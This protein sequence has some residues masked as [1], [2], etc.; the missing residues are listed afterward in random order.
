MLCR[1]HLHLVLHRPILQG[2]Q[3]LAQFLHLV[4]DV[5][6]LGTQALVVRQVELFHILSAC[7]MLSRGTEE[8]HYTGE[9]E[10]QEMP[11]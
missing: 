8:T 7:L 5:I 9:K 3:L 10:T 4:A 11:F 2:V 6:D 1:A